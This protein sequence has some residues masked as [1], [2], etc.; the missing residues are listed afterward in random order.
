MIGIA[1]PKFEVVQYCSLDDGDPM[2][3]TFPTPSTYTGQRFNYYL[4]GY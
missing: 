3:G 4:V 2:P 1:F